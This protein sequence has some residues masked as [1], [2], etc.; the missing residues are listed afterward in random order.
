MVPGSSEVYA[1]QELYRDLTFNRRCV[2]NA[3][4]AL[5][6]LQLLLDVVNVPCW[7]VL[8]WS[9]LRLMPC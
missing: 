8:E 4:R 2:L 7:L 9:L 5:R 1:Y 6:A 3:G